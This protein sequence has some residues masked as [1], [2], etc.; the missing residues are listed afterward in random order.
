M[1][2]RM[3]TCRQ[4]TPST[5]HAARC[6]ARFRSGTSAARHNFGM[7]W[8]VLGRVGGAA[9]YL[10]RSDVD[11]RQIHILSPTVEDVEHVDLSALGLSDLIER[12]AC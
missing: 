12:C 11:M 9:P 3:S 4:K 10:S 2:T 7:M 6:L 5:V 1:S 8:A